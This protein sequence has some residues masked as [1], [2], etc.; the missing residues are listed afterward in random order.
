MNK[1]IIIA[2][3][4]ESTRFVVK[5]ALSETNA[6]IIEAENGIE[7]L[8]LLDGRPI[9][10]LITDYNMPEMNGK[11]LINAVRNLE[12]YNSLPI[13]LLTGKER[14]L[15]DSSLAGQIQAWISKPFLKDDFLKTVHQHIRCE[16][17]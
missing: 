15:D 9:D 16:T 14:E 17:V 3:D 10:L 7:A 1:R 5:L 13:L 6:T 2:D 4:S 8:D 11:E 12:K